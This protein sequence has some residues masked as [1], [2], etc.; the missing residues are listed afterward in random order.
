MQTEYYSVNSRDKMCCQGSKNTMWHKVNKDLEVFLGNLAYFFRKEFFPA[1]D[2][3]M[4]T[5]TGVR[6]ASP[7]GLSIGVWD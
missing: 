6:T 5:E 3:V 1:R 7:C 4:E 2:A